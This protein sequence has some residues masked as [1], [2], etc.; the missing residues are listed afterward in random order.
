MITVT[1][2]S[3]NK[4]VLEGEGLTVDVDVTNNYDTAQQDVVIELLDFD[5]VVV[6]SVTLY[7]S[8]ET[9][10]FEPGTTESITLSW[11]M[12]PED[13]DE[14]TIT[15]QS[16]DDSAPQNILGVLSYSENITYLESNGSNRHVSQVNFVTYDRSAADTIQNRLQEVISEVGQEVISRLKQ[17]I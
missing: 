10:E 4:I 2:T 15:V 8:T 12:Q 7:P 5:N 1:I 9:A 3:I 6:D 14:N 11:D 16:E 13:S 17:D